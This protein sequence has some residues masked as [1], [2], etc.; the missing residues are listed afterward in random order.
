MQ[1][2]I[3]PVFRLVFY[4]DQQFSLVRPRGYLG[5]PFSAPKS[6]PYGRQTR[7]APAAGHPDACLERPLIHAVG[8]FP[9]TPVSDDEN[10]RVRVDFAGLQTF[11]RITISNLA[12][13]D[14][15]V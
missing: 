7:D 5:G 10:G 2:E 6:K 3:S 12:W 8:D 1:G 11:F 13:S 4:Y 15:G 14:P 9:Y